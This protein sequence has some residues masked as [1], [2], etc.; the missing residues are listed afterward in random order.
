MKRAVLLWVVLVVS[1]VGAAAG[2]DGSGPHPEGGSRATSQ[3]RPTIALVLSG[4]S[5]KGFAHIGA[6]QVFEDEGIPFDV[7]AGTSAG[8]LIGSLYAVGYTGREMEAIVT[9]PGLDLN[10]LFF[11]RVEGDLLRIEERQIPDATLVRFPLSGVTPSLPEG[12]VAGQRVMQFLSRYTWGYHQVTDLTQLPRPYSCNALDL[13]S[14]DDVI[15]STGFLPEVA[16][17]CISLPGFFEPLERDG[18]MLVDGGPSYM[19]PVPVARSLGGQVLVGVDVSGDIGPDGEV[20]LGPE[21]NEGNLL[22]FFVQTVG[23]SRRARVLEYRSALD[24]VVTP[25]VGG[26]NANDYNNA[27]YFIERGRQ[28]AR[29]MVPQLRALMDSLGHPTARRT[30]S[31]PALAPVMVGSLDIRGVDG[32]AERLVRGLLGFRLPGMLGPDDVDRA[33]ARVYGTRLFETVLYRMLPG[34]DGE[35]ATLR[36]D[37]KPLEEADR[38]GVGFRYDDSYAAA[39]L[40]TVELRNRLRYGSTTGL[41]FRLGRQTKADMSYFTRLGLAS[42]V[43]AGGSLGYVRAPL[44]FLSL[45]SGS[46]PSDPTDRPELTQSVYQGTG[47]LGLALTNTALLGVRGRAAYYRERVDNYPISDEELIWDGT[48]FRAPDYEGSVITGRY[49]SVAGFFEAGRF[50]RKAFPHAGYRVSL[51][52]EF[53]TAARNDDDFIKRIEDILGPLTRAPGFNVFQS[54][55][56]YV[57]DLEAAIPLHPAWTVQTRVAYSRGEGDG[58]PLNYLTAV[59]GIHTNSVFE[60][61]F[62]PLYGLETQERL[63]TEGWIARLAL[64]WEPRSKLFIRPRFSAGDAYINLTDAELQARPDLAG[65]N[66]FDLDRAALSLGLDLGYASPLGPALISVG[67][68]EGGKPHVGFGLGYDF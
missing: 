56:H 61:S 33:I 65:L 26:L 30:I 43:T 63:G 6:I 68:V 1:G 15:L 39:L 3:D 64:Q 21:G 17:T 16:R 35:P 11:D 51:E 18:M 36:V 52:A 19:L 67:V 40:F 25:D 44:R 66:G 53:G 4:G 14:G 34:D 55:R 10:D 29:A 12:V 48:R 5:A 45:I 8:S 38:L 60:G 37:V 50:D 27:P 62:Y 41:T 24:V 54:F 57:G 23:T 2:Q 28:A 49:R 59:G 20:R 22:S 13:I 58:L 46:Y 31:P 9:Q 42:P 7:V 47:W 32:T